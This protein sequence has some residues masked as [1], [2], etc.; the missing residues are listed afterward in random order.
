MHFAVFENEGDSILVDVGRSEILACQPL[1]LD[2]DV[3]CCCLVDIGP[4][5]TA[6]IVL[7]PVDLEEVELEI[8]EIRPVVARHVP[9]LIFEC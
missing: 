6:Q 1:D 9:F 4:R 2:E 3:T 5:T 8:P 7:Y